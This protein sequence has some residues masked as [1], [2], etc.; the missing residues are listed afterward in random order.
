MLTPIGFSHSK[1]GNIYVRYRC[2]CGTEKVIMRA[3]VRTGKT[4]SCGCYRSA[5]HKEHHPTTET[6]GMTGSPT[7]ISWIAM[8]RRCS[9]QKNASYQW[10]G[11]KGIAVCPEWQNSFEKFLADMGTKPSGC[12]ID[13][14]DSSKGYYKENCRW[15]TVL[16]QARQ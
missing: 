14:L 15:A 16:E 6:H 13:R 4:K 1:Q 5:Y 8:R 9:D 10:Y 3:M 12:S 7:Y 2:V 11:A